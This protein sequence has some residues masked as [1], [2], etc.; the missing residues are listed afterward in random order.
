M[1]YTLSSRNMENTGIV[2]DVIL[3]WKRKEK[4][5]DVRGK[6]EYF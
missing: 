4:G 1:A 5:T 2:N 3:I 6:K